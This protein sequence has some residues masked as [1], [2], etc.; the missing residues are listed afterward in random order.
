MKNNIDVEAMNDALAGP[1]NFAMF[2]F[3]LLVFF[4]AYFVVLIKT[5]GGLK[6]LYGEI[7]RSPQNRRLK[8]KFWICF[9]ALYAPV[10]LAIYFAV[11]LYLISCR[12]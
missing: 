2:G 9:V 6:V 5:N 4:V 10:V 7:K 1:V 8:L 3:M 11:N 12:K